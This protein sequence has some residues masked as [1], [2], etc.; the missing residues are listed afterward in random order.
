MHFKKS[1]LGS[2]ITLA[3]TASNTVVANEVTVDVS[4]LKSVGSEVSSKQTATSYIVQLKGNTAIAQAQD[5]GE[6]LPSNQLVANTG[7]NY[8]AYTPAMIAYTNA[9]QQKQQEVSGS[10]GS[11]EILHSFKHAYNGFTAKL[12]ATQKAQLESH[13]DVVGVWE[14]RLEIINTSNTPEFLGLTGPGGQHTMNVKGEDVI[15]GVIDTGIWPENPSFADDGSYTDPAVL[16]W[17]GACDTGTDEAFTCNNKLIGARYFGTSF[18]SVNEIQYDLGE[19]DR[20][21]G[22]HSNGRYI[23]VLQVRDF[24]P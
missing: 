1:I 8:N 9:M 14:D 15:I 2:L 16:G 23:A 21:Y 5:I 19:F 4:K 22:K 10:I 3:I 11:I 18:S 6:L 17:Q 20:Y 7:N 24:M 13:P 12:N